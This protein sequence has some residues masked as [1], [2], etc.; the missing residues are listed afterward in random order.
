MK[1]F[2]RIIVALFVLIGTVVGVY[3]IFFAR[4][5]DIDIFNNLSHLIIEKQNLDIYGSLENLDS[6]YETLEEFKDVKKL[7]CNTTPYFISEKKVYSYYVIDNFLDENLKNYFAYTKIATKVIKSNQQ[8]I[9]SCIAVYKKNLS[10]LYNKINQIKIYQ[11][12][13]EFET[14]ETTRSSMRIELNN[15]YEEIAD[16][17]KETLISEAKLCLI[18][19]DFI[20]VHSFN[21]DFYFD[22]NLVLLDSICYSVNELQNYII[23]N[24]FVNKLNEVAQI[25]DV[26]KD[27]SENQNIFLGTDINE[28]TFVAAYEQVYREIPNALIKVFEMSRIQ[29]LEFINGASLPEI[30]E[31]YLI[32][33]KNIL[34]V[35]GY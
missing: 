26:Y 13:Y 2:V 7:I 5:K 23:G 6:N 1:F 16:F 4:A 8:K 14:N 21:G 3:F 25:I 29:K 34:I 9:D 17:Y 35:L 31:N 24:A 22:T 18:L 10:N 12:A 15:K 20:N 27:F 19:R 30:E 32:D 28:N 33:L 11:M